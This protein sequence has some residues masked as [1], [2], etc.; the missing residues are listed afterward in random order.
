MARIVLG[1]GT[2][3]GP[4]LS[5]PPEQWHQRVAADRT[6]SHPY[7]GRRYN[8]D[9]LV[10]LRGAEQLVEQCEP[11]QM[12]DRFAQCRRAIGRLAQTWED[13]RPDVAI[14]VG[15]DQM[16]VFSEDNI[17]AMAVHYG[18]TLENV[19][20]S[21]EQTKRL[22]PGLA[23]AEPGHH[24]GHSE[25]FPGHPELA[26]H[27]LRT[28][29]THHFDAAAMR[30]LPHNPRSYSTGLPH[31]YGFVYRQII[32]EHLCPAVVVML[33]TFYPPNQPTAAR[34]H[35][36]GRAIAEAVAAWP[37]EERVAVVGSGGLSHF[38]VDETLDRGFLDALRQGDEQQLLSIG[39]ELFESGTSELK[40]WLPLAGA[41]RAAGLHMHLHDYV[42]CYRSEAGT[43]NGMGFAA[44]T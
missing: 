2:S 6:R 43:G 28:L 10:R 26:Q 3:H 9:E 39:E 1:I 40:N 21:E 20:Y 25:V 8:F 34:C 7:Q 13:V 44:W 27:L 23:I 16:E 37:G 41:M 33:N 29:T 31:A 38:V 14:L 35:A 22:Q 11:D 15:N 32:R 42:P 19:P 18:P 24:A 36:L 17:P 4:M 30:Q 5:T 12:A